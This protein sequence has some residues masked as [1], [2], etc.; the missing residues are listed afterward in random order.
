MYHHCYRQLDKLKK[1]QESVQVSSSNNA[2]SNSQAMATASSNNSAAN[3]VKDPMLFEEDK[4]TRIRQNMLLCEYYQ[5][6]GQ[7]PQKYLY[8]LQ[9]LASQAMNVVLD[10]APKC[11]ISSDGSHIVM[12]DWTN[13]PA[14]VSADGRKGNIVGQQSGK[15]PANNNALGGSAL[16]SYNLS[17]G[18]ADR[19]SGKNNMTSEEVFLNSIKPSASA[20]Q[21]QGSSA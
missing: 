5:Q 21:A 6:K 13:N 12:G 8:E 11:Q 14:Q 2:S 4:M 16:G 15:I 7:F 1:V 17:N 18:T 19:G 9:K 3:T 10:P 20:S